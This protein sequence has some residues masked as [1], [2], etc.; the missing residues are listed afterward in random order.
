[1]AVDE[2]RGR[3]VFTQLGGVSRRKDLT[4]LEYEST[5]LFQAIIGKGVAIDV[6]DR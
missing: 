3:K 6:D 2:F 1:L 5:E 4:G